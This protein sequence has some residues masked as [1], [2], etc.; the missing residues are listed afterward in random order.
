[1]L[2][3]GAG[4]RAT[5]AG[6]RDRLVFVDCLTATLNGLRHDRPYT[7]LGLLFGGGRSAIPRAVG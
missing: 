5:G 2:G 6:A 7:I 4:E 1:M 3:P